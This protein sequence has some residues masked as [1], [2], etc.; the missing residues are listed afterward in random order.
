M[1]VI[2]LMMACV[3]AACSTAGGQTQASAETA[4][5]ANKNSSATKAVLLRLQQPP[6]EAQLQ[7]LRQLGVNTGGIT[8]AIV[9]ASVP[10][11]QLPAVQ[12]LPFVERVELSHPR[13]KRQ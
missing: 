11:E 13:P 4:P 6:T 3:L 7:Q 8:G 1:R 9:S 5:M 10:A 2:L 12:A